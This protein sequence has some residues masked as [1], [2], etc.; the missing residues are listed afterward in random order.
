MDNWVSHGTTVTD[1]VS[2]VKEVLLPPNV[3]SV[4][5]PMDEGVIYTTNKKYWYQIL[6]DMHLIHKDQEELCK[7]S[8]EK[9]MKGGTVV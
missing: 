9:N 2:N 4:Y 7:A 8:I 1:P 5:Q 6:R 3:P